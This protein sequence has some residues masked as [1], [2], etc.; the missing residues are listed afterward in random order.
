MQV[1]QVKS[2][3]C[4]TQKK[5]QNIYTVHYKKNYA[6]NDSKTDKIYTNMHKTTHKNKR[7]ITALKSKRSITALKKR[8][9]TYAVYT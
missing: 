7:S 4:R 5:E 6:Y 2:M 8:S 1:E 9:S 3:L